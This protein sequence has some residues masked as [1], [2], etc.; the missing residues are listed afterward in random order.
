MTTV[1]PPGFGVGA[2][3]S[4]PPIGQEP[5][6]KSVMESK[7]NGRCRRTAPFLVIQS[8]S[9][10][11]SRPNST[12]GGD[13]TAVLGERSAVMPGLASLPPNAAGGVKGL[14]MPRIDR[15]A[16][17]LRSPWDGVAIGDRENGKEEPTEHGVAPKTL[18][19]RRLHSSGAGRSFANGLRQLLRHR[20]ANN[21]RWISDSRNPQLV[22]SPG[23]ADVQ[24]SSCAWRVG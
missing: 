10:G 16:H 3:G 9:T 18:L 8:E 12:A 19:R 17:R 15:S 13:T 21:R 20:L 2:M 4:L 23:T 5:E 22:D 1:G 11:C 7:S 14:E 24:Q 6:R